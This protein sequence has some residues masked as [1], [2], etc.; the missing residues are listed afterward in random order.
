MAASRY[1]VPFGR[2]DG[3]LVH[4]IRKDRDDEKARP[5][6]QQDQ[7]DQQEGRIGQGLDE[8]A[9]LLPL[10]F[11][12]IGQDTAESFE[13]PC[14]LAGPDEAAGQLGEG[15]ALVHGLGRT[16]S[17]LHLQGRQMERTAIAARHVG[18]QQL[19]GL[20]Q[21]DA[22]ADE[23]CQLAKEKGQQ[24]HGQPRGP[25]PHKAPPA[26]Q[27]RRAWSIVRIPAAAPVCM[28]VGS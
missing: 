5:C 8:E 13:V 10:G 7:A 25:A 1:C 23:G 2:G 28:T 24:G 11:I 15:P 12:E 26:R 6:R 18:H 27:R 22:A 20:Y 19:P 4:H 3:H 16:D 17:L 21:R 9:P 14:L